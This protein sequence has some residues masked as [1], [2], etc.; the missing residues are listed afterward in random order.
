MQHTKSTIEKGESMTNYDV[1]EIERQR[2]REKLAESIRNNK[3]SNEEHKKNDRFD[4]E[5]GIMSI[6]QTED[7]LETVLYSIMDATDGPPSED[8]I[9]NM[10]LGIKELHG[11]R[12]QRLWDTFENF[13]HAGHNNLWEDINTK[14][15]GDVIAGHRIH[16]YI[17]GGNS[18]MYAVHPDISEEDDNEEKYDYPHDAVS[19][20]PLQQQDEETRRKNKETHKAMKAESR[21]EEIKAEF[22]K[23]GISIMSLDEKKE[24]KT[25]S[26]K[27]F[28]DRLDEMD[29][30]GDDNHKDM[31]EAVIAQEEWDA[32]KFDNEDKELD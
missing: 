29:N 8:E 25:V 24:I 18:E 30:G 21:Q 6:W 26:M 4:L 13:V 3:K 27:E 32:T 16:D 10:I 17:G 19:P 23:N 15:Q 22:D 12:M 5:R 7:D 1:D 2:D 28:A 9:V 31:K 11:A 20:E 14:N